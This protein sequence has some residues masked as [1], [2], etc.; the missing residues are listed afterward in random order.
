MA[1]GYID[2]SPLYKGKENDQTGQL[3][4]NA[5]RTIGSA[6]GEFAGEQK[7]QKQNIYGEIE[8]KNRAIAEF[9]NNVVRDASQQYVDKI[10][11]ENIELL[12]KNRFFLNPQDKAKIQSNLLKIDEFVNQLKGF[13]QGSTQ[14]FKEYNSAK[15]MGMY[16]DPS[17]LYENVLESLTPDP[18]T[19][20]IDESK[21][22][23]S[24]NGFSNT[25]TGKWGLRYKPIAPDEYVF[26]LMKNW[27]NNSAHQG[28]KTMPIL[29]TYTDPKLGLVKA[30]KETIPVDWSGFSRYAVNALA[31][32]EQ[33]GQMFKF[34]NQFSPEE[35]NIAIAKYG[36]KDEFGRLNE[37]PLMPLM[38]YYIN[39]KLN[40]KDKQTDIVNYG[41][42]TVVPKRVGRG[43]SGDNYDDVQGLK[44]SKKLN[45][46]GFVVEEGYTNPKAV[47]RSY[48]FS[49]AKEIEG[50]KF[51]K[52]VD[53]SK[54]TADYTISTYDAASDGLVLVTDK[55][56]DEGDVYQAYVFVPRKGNEDIVKD[57]LGKKYDEI[58]SGAK[59]QTKEDYNS[60][61]RE[62]IDFWDKSGR[63]YSY[64][65]IA[66]Y[67]IKKNR[68]NTNDKQEIFSIIEDFGK[69]K[70][71]SSLGKLRK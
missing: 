14:A 61:A 34:I 54:E 67:F 38:E 11:N 19:G 71:K 6:I 8:E 51:G 48:T 57:Y 2:F 37:N 15:G 69:Q 10:N 7:A 40:I 63:V 4:G 16:E 20:N 21:L 46:G 42:A 13:E 56:D 22:R 5:I 9:T 47:K 66:D 33:G 52:P 60:I 41:P 50:K 55:K 29:E 1:R 43:G 28:E 27:M 31:S 17:D 59:P 62:M 44:T 45:L 23:M 32:D 49:G 65:E 39:D 26:N 30:S 68:F 24:L 3:Y 58:T 35:Q 12:R 64:S 25:D 70:M 53:I 18:S 36:Q